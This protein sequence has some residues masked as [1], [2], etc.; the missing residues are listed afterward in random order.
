MT[1]LSTISCK[2]LFSLPLFCNENNQKNLPVNSYQQNNDRNIPN[3]TKDN[4]IYFTPNI[5]NFCGK[6]EKKFD[7]KNKS[8]LITGGTG[9]I[10]ESLIKSLLKNNNPKKIIIFSRDETKQYKMKLNGLNDSRLEYVA[11]DVKDYGD[12]RRAFKDVDVVIHTAAMKHIPMCESKTDEAV[13]TNI[14]GTRNLINA[15]IDSNVKRV[16]YTSSSR[17]TA[18]CN[19][20]GA[21]K[22]ISE[23]LLSQA[24]SEEGTKF[25]SVRLGNVLGSNGNIVSVFK[26]QSKSG[27][28]K[29]TDPR[30]TRFFMDTQ[31]VSDFIV[32]SIETMN[33][34][35]VFVPKL[36]SI[37]I[38]ELAKKVGPDCEIEQI[39][40]RPGEDLNDS[41][42]SPAE[43]INTVETNDRFIILPERQI[44]K[45]EELWE[46][47]KKV[48]KDFD[49]NSSSSSCKMSE[50]ELEK[51]VNKFVKN[52]QNLSVVLTIIPK[53]KQIQAK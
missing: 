39:G 19:V 31:Q 49:Y 18:A 7:L 11:G 53:S 42:I 43:V 15:A 2:N 1:Y 3:L 20:Y 34:G 50:E 37:N 5:T 28:I 45:A 10:A 14:D 30:M 52:P 24:N 12:L 23:K 22:L 46:D 32:S 17:A 21:T 25:S 48:P 38:L 29:V 26:E 40:I 33:G 9:S 13:S 47:C 35:E 16:I 41:F 51:L 27:K 44:E 36:K 4:I 8:I 6:P